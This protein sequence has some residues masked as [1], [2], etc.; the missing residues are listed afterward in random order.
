LR[1]NENCLKI[2][3]IDTGLGLTRKSLFE[4]LARSETRKKEEVQER[5][6]QA[7]KEQSHEIFG[8]I[9]Y[10]TIGELWPGGEPI[11]VFKIIF[12]DFIYFMSNVLSFKRLMLKPI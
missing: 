10:D 6:Q 5:S 12:T 2:L 9:F 7:S 1:Q 4:I 3:L 8:A 11:T